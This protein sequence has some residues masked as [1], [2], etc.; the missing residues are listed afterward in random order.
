MARQMG[1]N[2]I[3]PKN[4][5]YNALRG[6]DVK[7]ETWEEEMK[8]Q[9]GLGGWEAS[10]TKIIEPGQKEKWGED[11]R[12]KKIEDYEHRDNGSDCST[13]TGSGDEE[14][15]REMLRM[16]EEID[17]PPEKDEGNEYLTKA[18]NNK[19]VPDGTAGKAII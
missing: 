7:I 17:R 6:E 2:A 1:G 14:R 12:V 19:A 11:Q 5:N 13:S 18:K 9:G 15:E 16:D 4:R 8:K 10:K 3:G